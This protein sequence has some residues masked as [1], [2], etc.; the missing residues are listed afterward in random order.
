MARTVLEMALIGLRY[1]LLAVL[2]M[3]GFSS[4]RAQP[5][6]LAAKSEQA[7][8]AMAAGMFAEAI[9]LYEQLVAAVPKNPGLLTNLG[10]AQHMAGRDRDA[11][12]QFDAAL[13]IDPSIVPASIFKGVSHL[14]LGQPDKA[15]A[16]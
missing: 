16:P 10:M 15:I 5:Q 6:E 9:P 4:L 12:R 7:K 13:K 11:I 3:G 14:R 1:V 2:G 8:K